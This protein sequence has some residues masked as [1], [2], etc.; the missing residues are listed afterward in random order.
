MWNGAL[1][2]RLRQNVFDDHMNLAGLPQ[3]V[4][5]ILTSEAKDI[6]C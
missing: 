6:G 2:F 3:T 5:Y 1:Y 4:E